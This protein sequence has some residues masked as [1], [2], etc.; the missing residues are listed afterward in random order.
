MRS[1]WR[2]I[3]LVQPDHRC[4]TYRVA[5]HASL[6][7]PTSRSRKS[8]EAYGVIVCLSEE[9]GAKKGQVASLDGLQ[10]VVACDNRI[11]AG[12]A[13][14]SLPYLPRSLNEVMNRSASFD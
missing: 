10:P 9:P 1:C 3:R 13:G 5:R 14:R 8:R 2:T 4:G 7:C 12:P 11:R 6:A